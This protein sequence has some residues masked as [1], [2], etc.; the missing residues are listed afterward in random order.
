MVP[1]SC[2]CEGSERPKQSLFWFLQHILGTRDCHVSA[3]STP[4]RND[5]W[6]VPGPQV[7]EIATSPKIRA[8]RNDVG[9]G[10]PFWGSSLQDLSLSVI[11]SL[12][13]EAWQSLFCIP[14]YALGTRDC[15]VRAKAPFLAMTAGER[16]LLRRALSI[17]RNNIIGNVW[18][19]NTRDCHV[20]SL[21]AMTNVE[22]YGLLAMT[23]GGSERNPL[24]N[25]CMDSPW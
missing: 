2:H 17:L 5:S 14:Q 13:K 4:P 22:M 3:K 16:R 21:L 9:E 25:G 6:E 10:P 1:K 15:R 12:R 7:P 24:N 8:P 23:A 20:V 18:F 11:A 19:P